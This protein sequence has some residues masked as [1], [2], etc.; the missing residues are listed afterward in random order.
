MQT[1]EIA[2][3]DITA[4]TKK[5][6][7]SKFPGQLRCDAVLE[8]VCKGRIFADNPTNPTW[9]VVQ[10]SSFGTLFWAGDVDTEILRHFV[11]TLSSQGDVLIGLYE[12][13]MRTNLLPPHPQYDGHT[14][15]FTDRPALE[16]LSAYLQPI[17]D[18]CIFRRVDRALFERSMDYQFYSDMFGSAD[19]AL[20]KTL[21]LF[22]MNGETILCEAWAGCNVSGTIEIGVNTIESERR[23]GYA[24]ATCARLILA[25]EALGYQTYWNCAKQN[26]ASRALAQKLGYRTSVEYCLLGWF[27]S[28]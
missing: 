14:I 4:A 27:P 9:C 24:T 15:D 19:R 12:N 17:P 21:G 8:G 3:A 6:F 26:T 28:T 22:L 5:L 23:K 16:G 10:E 11:D 18:R 25:C 1:V 2:A 20:E 7:T 13:D